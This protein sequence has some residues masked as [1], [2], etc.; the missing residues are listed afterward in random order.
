MIELTPQFAPAQIRSHSA[1]L[2]VGFTARPL[3]APSM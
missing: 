3:P 2:R 1:A